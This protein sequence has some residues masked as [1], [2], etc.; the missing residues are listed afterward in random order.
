MSR[1]SF[2]SASQSST[3]KR[4]YARY[5]EALPAGKLVWIGLRPARKQP[6]QVVSSCQAIANLGL[7]GDHRV[8]KTPGSGRQVTLISAEFIHSIA[9][10]LKQPQIDP[11]L[12]RRNLVVQ[13]INL[14]A[15]RYQRFRIGEAVFEANAQCHPCARMEEALGL[16]GVSAMLGYGGLCCKVIESGN[17][18]L[19]DTVEVIPLQL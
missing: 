4:W 18:T 16:G 14:N 15:L 2:Q 1:P 3:Q 5:A 6:L 9:G 13:G 10:Y 8:H 7:E 19:G 11:A 17:L 12:L